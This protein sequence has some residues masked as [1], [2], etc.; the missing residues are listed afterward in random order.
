[1]TPDAYRIMLDR[2]GIRLGLDHFVD[3]HT[4]YGRDY[5]I[6]E[7][8]WTGTALFVTVREGGA[9]LEPKSLSPSER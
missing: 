4:P 7:A 6:V 5:Q 9:R 3:K 2:K 1:M 8:T